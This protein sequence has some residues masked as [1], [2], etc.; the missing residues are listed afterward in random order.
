MS[1]SDSTKISSINKKKGEDFSPLL[2]EILKSVEY[3]YYAIM[4][5]VFMFITSD[6]YISQVL[7]KINGA[8]EFHLTTP[9][10]TVIQAIT[11]IIIMI[12]INV[13]IKKE[14]L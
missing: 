1:D 14:I 9:Y 6:I 13:L 12:I 7:S 10:G 3:K 2:V 8:L 5:I 4:F 11:L